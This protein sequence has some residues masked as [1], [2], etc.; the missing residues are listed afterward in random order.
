MSN[1]LKSV[2][3]H[4]WKKIIMKET[5]MFFSCK[6]GAWWEEAAIFLFFLFLSCCCA[7][8]VS[9]R[10]GWWTGLPSGGV[11]G[12]LTPRGGNPGGCTST[13]HE[14]FA[15]TVCSFQS[16]CEPG[17]HPPALFLPLG[18]VNL[19]RLAPK[20]WSQA[21]YPPFNFSHYLKNVFWVVHGSCFDKEEVFSVW[22][23]SH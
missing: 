23:S 11:Q 2:Y 19:G 16:S 10:E 18:W 4:A 14:T 7:W 21:L 15:V 9:L 5:M 17:L 22:H 6:I 8:K 13:C 20:V 1:S 12:V 3:C